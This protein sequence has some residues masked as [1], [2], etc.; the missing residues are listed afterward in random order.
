[1]Y[2]Q[3]VLFICYPEFHQRWGLL[4]LISLHKLTNCEVMATLTF[5]IYKPKSIAA[6]K[7]PDVQQPC[8]ELPGCFYGRNRLTW[9]SGHLEKCKWWKRHLLGLPAGIHHWTEPILL[10]WSAGGRSYIVVWEYEIQN[11]KPR[12][13]LIMEAESFSKL[14]KGPRYFGQY[15]KDKD[16]MAITL[17]D[18]VSCWL[19]QVSDAWL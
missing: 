6:M 14:L 8:T 15:F 1:M 16:C 19:L 13:F 2:S 7:L 12:T 3:L 5:K 4:Y 18:I 9:L 10:H 17:E 11:Y